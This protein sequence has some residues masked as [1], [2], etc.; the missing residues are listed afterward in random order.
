MNNSLLNATPF[1]GSAIRIDSQFRSLLVCCIKIYNDIIAKNK[2][3]KNDE[4]TIRDLFFDEYLNDDNYRNQNKELEDFHFEKEPK[5]N[6]GYLDIKAK[7]LNPYVS[8]KAYFVIE[9]KRLDSNNLTGNTGLNAEYIKNGV[10]RFVEDY[11][12]SYYDCNA[13]FGF[14]VESVNVQNDIVD[15]INSMLNK[16][17]TLKTKKTSRIVN[18]KAT[19]VMQY[20][21]FANGYQYSYIS[22][23]THTS[24]KNIDLY[25]LMFDLSS[26]IIS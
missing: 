7:K 13:M 3:T 23:H 9:C 17:F 15:N 18:A 12:S 1:S 21:D 20:V 4:E 19:Q 25:H 2:R 22:K 6:I 11:Y 14:I 16:D 8:T 5:E 26:I 10:C 24:G